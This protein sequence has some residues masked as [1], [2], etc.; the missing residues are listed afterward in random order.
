M[1]VLSV[2]ALSPIWRT[3]MQVE[4]A[5]TGYP[6]RPSV[7]I[8]ISCSQPYFILYL[9]FLLYNTSRPSHRHGNSK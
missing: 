6:N 4:K 9:L 3:V 1:Y 2:K 5:V 8:V 7:D